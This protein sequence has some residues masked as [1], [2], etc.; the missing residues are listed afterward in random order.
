MLILCLAAVISNQLT[1]VKCAPSL[2]FAPPYI[3]NKTL[4]I[5][6]TIE[7]TFF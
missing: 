4:S 1:L 7:L 3:L 2:F 6:P 5:R